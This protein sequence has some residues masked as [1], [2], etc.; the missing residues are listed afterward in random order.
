MLDI[1][2]KEEDEDFGFF[3]VAG[4]FG[5]AEVDEEGAAVGDG[6]HAGY[7]LRGNF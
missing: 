5:F 6:G 2:T 4:G 7:I 3:R 1:W